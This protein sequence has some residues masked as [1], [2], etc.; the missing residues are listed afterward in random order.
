[1]AGVTDSRKKD[2][3]CI[4]EIFAGHEPAQFTVQ[5]IQWEPEIAEKWLKDDPLLIAKAA[6]AAQ[7]AEEA[8]EASK[9]IFEGF[10]DPKT[11]KFP[12][13]E[14]KS[15]FPKGVFGK[16]KE[17]YLSDEDFEATF[18]MKMAEYEKLKG[19]KQMDLKKKYGL[20]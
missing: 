8:K 4:T 20:F 10:L 16:K 6:A 1:L 19:W 11:N 5:F 12:L 17:Y 7:A 13:D 9:D 3:V 2:E 14:L 15:S 18:S